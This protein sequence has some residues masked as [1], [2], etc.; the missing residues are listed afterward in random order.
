MQTVDNDFK[1]AAVEVNRQPTAGVAISWLRNY[2][3]HD[4][5]TIGVSLIGGTDVIKGENNVIAEGDNYEYINETPYLISLEYER[6]FTEPIYSVQRGMMDLILDNNSD[7]F[8]PEFDTKIGDSIK[9]RRPIRIYAGFKYNGIVNNIQ[10]MIGTINDY[11]IVNKKNKQL[12]L[13]A[14]DFTEAL[15]NIPVEETQLYTDKRSDELLQI[16]LEDAGLTTGQ[17]SLDEG[18]ITIPFAF[19]G[20]GDKIGNI[21]KLICE[22]E[23][24]IFY[25]DENGYF[26]FENRTHWL[27]D[28]HTESQLT[29]TDDM[30]IKE[31]Q[32]DLKAIVNVVEITAKPRAVVSTDESIFD[33]PDTREIAAGET[34][35]V[36]A[37][38]DDPVYSLVT[39]TRGVGASSYYTANTE[40]GG[41]G[42]DKTAQVDLS[43][44][45]FSTASK[46]EFTNNDAGSVFLTELIIF[47][48]PA[49]ITQ[50]LYLKMTDDDSI[51]EYDEHAISITNDYI[52]S[53]ATM[54]SIAI[55]I[56][57]NRKDPAKYKKMT[58]IGQP[59]LQLGDLVT[60][61]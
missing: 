51:A 6:K 40:S 59:H 38:Y 5:F 18:F 45:N 28:P 2:Y 20:K 53:Y 47:G 58:I 26:R 34:I 12:T 24:G 31:E 15:W 57:A 39:P 8:T 3:G 52:Q 1:A 7:R 23:Q 41:G 9:M 17:F 60:R 21:I 49:K 10:Q 4:W 32:P 11:P 35:E 19:F 22:A 42:T 50:E 54:R 33:L 48:K 13:H 56:L 43:I 14:I 46:L 36:W 27:N 30:I 16:I 55:S 37:N 29:I 61:F 44:T 25:V